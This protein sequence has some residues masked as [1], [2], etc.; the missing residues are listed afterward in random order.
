MLFCSLECVFHV[1]SFV[2]YY[3]FSI[4]YSTRNI[5][6]NKYLLMM[7]RWMSGWMDEW[8]TD[9]WV[10]GWMD[11]WW[12]DDGWMTDGWICNSMDCS[13]SGSSVHGIL[14][15][16]ILEWVAISSSRGS[17]R[18]KG[19]TRI[20]YIVF[21]GRQVLYHLAP[22]GK[23]LYTNRRISWEFGISIYKL[24]YIK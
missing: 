15:P 19:W 20:F 11:G 6:A 7:N 18:P 24:L 22:S 5:S 8:L 13:P 9:G 16:R 1:R 21:I 23:P 3:I 10:D 4:Q 17:S 14:L 12:M 2:F